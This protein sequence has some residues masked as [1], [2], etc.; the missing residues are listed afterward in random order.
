FAWG[1]QSPLKT[2]L[3]PRRDGRLSVFATGMMAE[4]MGLKDNLLHSSSH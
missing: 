1:R 2:Q 4:G 3:F